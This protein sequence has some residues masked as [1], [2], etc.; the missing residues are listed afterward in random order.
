MTKIIT[1]RNSLTKVIL[2]SNKQTK[3]SKKKQKKTTTT[4][5]KRKPNN[6]KKAKKRQNGVPQCDYFDAMSTFTLP[7]RSSI[8]I[9]TGPSGRVIKGNVLQWEN[10]LISPLQDKKNYLMQTIFLWSTSL[11]YLIRFV[12]S[13]LPISTWSLH[14]QGNSIIFQERVRVRLIGREGGRGEGGAENRRKE[15]FF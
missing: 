11:S 2:A 6:N 8:I 9:L 15:V 5:N 1:D 7:R 3:Q 12:E 13:V 10:K 14:W 4:E